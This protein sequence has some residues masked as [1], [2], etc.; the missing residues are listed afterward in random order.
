MSSRYW[1]GN[2][3]SG[4]YWTNSDKTA[5]WEEHIADAVNYKVRYMVQLLMR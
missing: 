3:K 2:K 5:F 1:G 4:E